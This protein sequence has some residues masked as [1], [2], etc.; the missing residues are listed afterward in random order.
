MQYNILML[1]FVKFEKQILDIAKAIS[2]QARLYKHLIQISI[3]TSYS[4]Q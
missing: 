3:L 4:T 2:K 1:E